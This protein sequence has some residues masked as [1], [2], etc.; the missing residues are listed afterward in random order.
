MASLLTLPVEILHRIFSE[1]DGTTVFL[2]VRKVCRQLRQATKTHHQY[3]LNLTSLSKP[4]FDQLSTFIHPEYVTSLT[5]SDGEMTPGQIAVFRLV[6]DV[7]LFTR[8]RSLTLLE[9]DQWNLGI[10]LE[11]ARRCFLSSLNIRTRFSSRPDNFLLDHLSAIINQPTLLHLELLGAQASN[12]I[13]KVQLL[14]QCKLQH[15]SL[16]NYEGKRMLK[17]LQCA[18]DLET[19]ELRGQII[20]VAGDDLDIN[21]ISLTPHPRLTSLRLIHTTLSMHNIK[22]ILSKTPA[23]T[24]LQI[25]GD[26][27]TMSNGFLWESCIQKNLPLLIKFE[28]YTHLYGFTIVEGNTE[29]VLKLKIASFSTR[30][31]TEEKRW[32]VICNWLVNRNEFE[33][34]TAPTGNISA[35]LIFDENTKTVSNFYR[36]R[37]P[38]TM[39]DC[40]KL[41]T[42]IILR[43][44]VSLV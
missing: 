26:D 8:L 39:S 9:I 31:W 2:S 25:V 35:P 43:R 30:F 32:L 44:N 3:K 36:K 33:I 37:Q 13:D 14:I 41:Y 4:D 23:L 12:L 7:D 18:S 17:I 6:F 27:S 16:E 15:I 42:A 28:L 11:H 24:H 21:V 40:G 29:V 38:S 5:V 10:F 19:L 1:L 22:S 34:F 20:I